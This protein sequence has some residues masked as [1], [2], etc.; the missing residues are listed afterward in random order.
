MVSQGVP[1]NGDWRKLVARATEQSG[2][3]TELTK[4]QAIAVQIVWGSGAL[5]GTPVGT[6]VLDA[7]RR[8]ARPPTGGLWLS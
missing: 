6:V 8:G 1:S 5:S 3:S 4:S 7:V 2:P